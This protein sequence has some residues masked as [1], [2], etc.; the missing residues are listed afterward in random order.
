MP[1]GSCR[2]RWRAQLRL[3]DERVFLVHGH[4]GLEA[5]VR[6]A[7]LHRVVGLGIAALG[8]VLPWRAARGL[9][10]GGVDQRGL[11]QPQ[12]GAAPPRQPVAHQLLALRIGDAVAVLQEK[13]LEDDQG[14]TRQ[15]AG[16]GGEQR[17][18]LPPQG[19]PVHQRLQPFEELVP[20]NLRRQPVQQP[21]LR[22][23]SLSHALLRLAIRA[24]CS[25]VLQRS[26]ISK[27]RPLFGSNYSRRKAGQ[28]KTLAHSSPF[29]RS[30]G[31]A[32][33]IY[34]TI[35]L[36]AP[37]AIFFAHKPSQFLLHGR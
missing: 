12:S 32:S 21:E 3:A 11:V 5:V 15:P 25:G 13:H 17:L 29:P 4:V 33:L 24:A 37:I 36:N 14:R 31:M 16:R 10:Q 7:V 23:R 27:N 28:N 19:R 6:P 34:E 30:G 26:H 1:R 18:Q 9:E 22:H 20:R 8:I 2:A 35:R